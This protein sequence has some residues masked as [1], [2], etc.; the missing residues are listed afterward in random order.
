M[1]LPEVPRTE[2]TAERLI[3]W[4]CRNC[5]CRVYVSLE[6]HRPNCG[7]IKREQKYPQQ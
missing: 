6:L 4:E 2:G 1:Q 5:G 7:L 3:P